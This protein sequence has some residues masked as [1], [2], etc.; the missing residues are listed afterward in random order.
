MADTYIGFRVELASRMFKTNAD[1]TIEQYNNNNAAQ[2]FDFYADGK[3]TVE[4]SGTMIIARGEK[5]NRKHIVTSKMVNFSLMVPVDS[6]DVARIVQIVNV[7]GNGRLIRER[8]K[9]FTDG[10]SAL[11][12]LP[13]L[14]GMN[15]AFDS[16]DVQIPGFI[17]CGWYYAPEA[18]LK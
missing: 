16:L 8:V 13:E 17:M 9:T 1:K 3:L 7:L 2:I 5:D 18:K 11:N 6:N 14:Y 4:R 10:N 12:R 15:Q